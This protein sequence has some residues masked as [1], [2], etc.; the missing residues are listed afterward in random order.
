MNWGKKEKEKK[1]G[2]NTIINSLHYFIEQ[3]ESAGWGEDKRREDY[4]CHEPCESVE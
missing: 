2:L 4:K 1:G 3:Q